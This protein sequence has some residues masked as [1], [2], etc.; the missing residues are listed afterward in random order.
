MIADALEGRFA[1]ADLHLKRM[2][3]ALETL[4]VPPLLLRYLHL[5]FHKGSAA[6]LY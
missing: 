3:Q 6:R 5:R 2:L 4:E 1:H